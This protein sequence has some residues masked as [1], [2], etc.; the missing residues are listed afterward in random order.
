MTRPR[1]TLRVEGMDGRGAPCTQ[2]G[3]LLLAMER[4]ARAIGRTCEPPLTRT[5]VVGGEGDG[6]T[7]ELVVECEAAEDSN[8]QTR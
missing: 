3:P 5:V 6:E 1:L 8:D 7:L 2:L 4:L